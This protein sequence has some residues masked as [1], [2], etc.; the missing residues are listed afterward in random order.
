MKK[1]VLT[2]LLCAITI[3]SLTG[4]KKKSMV[5]IEE[6]NELRDSITDVASTSNDNAYKN[7]TSC[8]VDEE[9]MA[10][11]VT[12]VDNSKESQQWFRENIKDS[13]YIK[14]ADVKRNTSSNSERD[15][16]IVKPDY[17]NDIKFNEY[18]KESTR[19]IFLA[20]NITD[21]Y[22][23]NGT[24]KDVLNKYLSNNSSQISDT[25]EF[26]TSKL[27][28]KNVLK[29]G[30]TTIYRSKDKDVTMIVCNTLDKTH[31]IYIGDFSINYEQFMCR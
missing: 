28:K 5:S 23:I 7:F 3:L 30:G 4:C 26:M 15:F 13:N 17:H 10:V 2:I 8:Y 11:V 24:K 14:F 31:D 27:D 16:Y 25:L 19:K 12:L 21:V 6:L 1:K 9:K 29:D 22:I 20:S 18:F